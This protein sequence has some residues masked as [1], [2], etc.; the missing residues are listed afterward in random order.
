MK[1]YNFT[2][3]NLPFLGHIITQDEISPDS[4]IIQQIQKFS[5]PINIKKLRSFL[6]LA[7]YY[8]KF[9][10]EFSQIAVP[11]FKLLKND[12]IFIWIID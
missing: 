7:G 6:G 9:I 12:I 3:D 8:R 4:L 11:L 5:I 10:K 1:K 2:Q